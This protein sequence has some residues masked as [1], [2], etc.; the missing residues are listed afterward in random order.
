M[1]ENVKI[2]LLACTAAFFFV[3]M[4]GVMVN[5]IEAGDL[6]W[7][8]KEAKECRTEVIAWEKSAIEASCKFSKELSEKDKEIEGLEQAICVTLNN[9]LKSMRG[10]K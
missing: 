4:L 2:L 10:K 1:K 7:A 8:R 5:G 3:T 9:Y 6:K